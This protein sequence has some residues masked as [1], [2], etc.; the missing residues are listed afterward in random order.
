MSDGTKDLLKT[1]P[2]PAQTPSLRRHTSSGFYGLELLG[3]RVYG[4]TDSGWGGAPPGVENFVCFLFLSRAVE[5]GAAACR[6]RQEVDRHLERSNIYD[7]G[8][9]QGK[10]SVDLS[11]GW[12]R[13][14]IYKVR[15]VRL[16]G[17]RM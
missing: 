15:H 6:G 4:Y 12:V 2:W 3:L 8:N 5:S 13:D 14:G 17:Y 9:D 16:Q 11:R 1:T 7:L 10:R